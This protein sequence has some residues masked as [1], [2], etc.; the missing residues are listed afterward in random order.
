MDSQLGMRDSL[1]V[2]ENTY[3]AATCNCLSLSG[4]VIRFGLGASAGRMLAGMKVP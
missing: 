3:A 1:T 4:N 2:E